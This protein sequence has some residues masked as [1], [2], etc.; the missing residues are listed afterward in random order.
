MSKNSQMDSFSQG[1]D[2]SDDIWTVLGREKKKKE[3][4][5]PGYFCEISTRTTPRKVAEWGR[6]PTR[7]AKRQEASLALLTEFCRKGSSWGIKGGPISWYVWML[8][9]S[10]VLTEQQGSQAVPRDPHPRPGVLA[11][12]R[13]G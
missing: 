8:S 3:G 11:P 13:L 9:R 10:P 2:H 1:A 7:T 5:P 6:A 12:P 4:N